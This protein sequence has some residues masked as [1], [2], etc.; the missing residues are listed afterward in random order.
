M[1]LASLDGALSQFRDLRPWV[2]TP[3]TG[4]TAAVRGSGCWLILSSVPSLRGRVTALSPFSA[5]G[6]L[7]VHV[8]VI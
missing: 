5:A 2:H 6:R 1:Q 8:Q 3:G 4:T 7:C